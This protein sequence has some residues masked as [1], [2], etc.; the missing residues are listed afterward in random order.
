MK[1]VLIVVPT[2]G[3]G[4]GEKFVM[5]LA[6]GMDRSTFQVK[7]LVLYPESGTIFDRFAA[8][9]G[10]DVIYLDKKLG[11]DCTMLA[12]VWRIV[13]DYAPDVIH[14]NLDTMLYL[15][16]SYR[17]Q[18]IKLHTVHTMADKEA[19]GLQRIVRKIAF[20]FVGVKPVAISSTVADSICDIYG[21]RR[22]KV[23][24]VCN[25]VVCSRYA[26]PK[27]ES[28]KVRLISVGSLYAVKNFPFLIHCFAAVRQKNAN[29]H[30]TLVGDGVQRKELETLIRH[31]GLE[32]D[33]TLTGTVADVENYLAD[34]D[35]YVASSIFEGLPLS[36]LEAM[37]AGLPVISTNVGGIAEIVH[38]GRNGMLVEPENQVAYIAALERMILDEELRR[39]YGEASYEI[40]KEYDVSHMIAGYEKLYRGK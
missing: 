30:L 5:D 37:A 10:L 13:R 21:I 26:L 34:A 23:P 11:L 16:P 40:A 1:K 8:E 35:I 12:K 6:N 2:L 15:L 29:V 31:L 39:R 20:W 32:Q 33:V 36:V 19:A 3:A 7:I 28:K 24:V 25:G 18:Q 14:S 9:N 17:R 22:H 27:K 4:G 38:N